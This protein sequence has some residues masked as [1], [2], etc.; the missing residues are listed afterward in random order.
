MTTTVTLAIK[1][2]DPSPGTV[3]AITL[4]V[5]AS[6]GR[7]TSTTS[8]TKGKKAITAQG[9]HQGGRVPFGFTTLPD[10]A[11]SFSVFAWD[12]LGTGP[13]L[14]RAMRYRTQG[15][16]LRETAAYLNAKGMPAPGGGEWSHGI[17]RR[18]C[19]Q[20][21]R[22]AHLIPWNALSIGEA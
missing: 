17:V 13:A 16:T 9:G 4:Y 8:T 5:E 6:G 22:H 2:T 18:V 12:E 20:A 21:Q 7:V 19:A 3:D 15:Y 1:I 11:H 14:V 10:D